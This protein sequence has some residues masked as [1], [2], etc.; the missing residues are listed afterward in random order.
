[1]LTF[2]STITDY[3]CKCITKVSK[4]LSQRQ[5]NARKSSAIPWETVTVPVNSPAFIIF[6]L[7][8]ENKT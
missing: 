3:H 6:H 4:L 8:Y 1:M 5:I 2:F 7:Y